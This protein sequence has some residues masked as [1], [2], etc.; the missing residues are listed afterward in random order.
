MVERKCDL[1][2]LGLDPARLMKIKQLFSQEESFSSPEIQSQIIRE[3][4]TL[5]HDDL[6]G[7]LFVTLE[8]NANKE[9]QEKAS[10][11]GEHFHQEM[12]SSVHQLM[13]VLTAFVGS[14]EVWQRSTK[15]DEENKKKIKKIMAHGY[16]SFS[17]AEHI[18][19]VLKNN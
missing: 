6:E 16:E 12:K 19:N 5:W 13:N 15:L 10:V 4:R 18:R 2:H 11:I 7:R 17:L 9:E 3:I 8:Q 14:L 1:S